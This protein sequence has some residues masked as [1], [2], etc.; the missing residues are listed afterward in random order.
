MLSSCGGA[1]PSKILS[2]NG[3]MPSNCSSSFS[4]DWV[5]GVDSGYI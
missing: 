2:P 4:G 5:K 3:V 1:C